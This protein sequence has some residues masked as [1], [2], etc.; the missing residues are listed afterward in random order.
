MIFDFALLHFFKGQNFNL[1]MPAIFAR[2]NFSL[3]HTAQILS[4]NF[5]PANYTNFFLIFCATLPLVFLI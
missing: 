5:Y 2:R 4:S 3:Y 1:K